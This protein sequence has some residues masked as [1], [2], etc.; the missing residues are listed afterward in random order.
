M[1]RQPSE[2]EKIFANEET[3]KGITSKIYKQLMQFSI[4]KNNDLI[5]KW[6]NDL[7]RHLSKNIQ[8]VNKHMTRCSASLIIREM[9]IKTTMR[10]RLT[11][12]RV[13]IIKMSTNNKCGKGE[14]VNSTLLM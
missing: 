2:W 12:I 14:I 10:Y 7:H 13:A 4:K 1:K 8:M 9:Q 6:L 5:K 3:D 11:P